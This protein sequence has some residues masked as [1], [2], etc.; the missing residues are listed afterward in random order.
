MKTKIEVGVLAIVIITFFAG[1]TACTT[2][3]DSPRVI[4][5]GEIAF[6]EG[7][8][9]LLKLTPYQYKDT[10]PFLK[11]SNLNLTLESMARDMARPLSEEEMMAV[12]GDHPPIPMSTAQF[13][14]HM[15]RYAA[16]FQA[17]KV[18]YSRSGGESIYAVI[19]TVVQAKFGL[20]RRGIAFRNE[21][22]FF[23]QIIR[24]GKPCGVWTVEAKEG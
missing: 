4:T 5:A 13:S 19:A 20:A 10:K 3:K 2:T 6:G 16:T 8:S 21:D 22:R 14:E 7:Y 23:V 9:L 12:G 11:K 1:L 15:H 17:E 18:W 24:D